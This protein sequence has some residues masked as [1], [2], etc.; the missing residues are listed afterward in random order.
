MGER[1]ERS[2]E[3]EE[4]VEEEKK[5]KVGHEGSNLLGP[6]TFEALANGRFKCVETGH[7]MPPNAVDSYSQSKRCRLGLIDFA[8]S[9]KKT[10][11]NLFKQDPVSRSKLICK[12]TGDTINKTEEHIWKHINGRRFLNKLEQKEAEKQMSNRKVVDKGDQ[13]QQ[14][15]GEKHKKKDK[16]KKDEKKKKKKQEKEVDENISEARKSE[17]D[18]ID[19]N[20]DTEEAEF[21]MPPVGDRWDSDDGGDRW[22]SGSDL[23]CDIDEVNGTDGAE[24]EHGN[25]SRELSKRTKRLSIEVGPSSFASRK[26]KS[27]TNSK[28]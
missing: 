23:E 14:K 17:V 3:E 18:E 7:E 9:H 21:W 11:L 2:K 27:K 4:K 5:K 12:L 6:P 24:E 16:K 1:R 20:S 8:L 15:D 13:M 19:K 25:E 22:G 10:P 28:C 26:K